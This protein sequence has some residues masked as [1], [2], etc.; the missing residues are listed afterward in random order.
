MST[1]RAFVPSESVRP[2][3]LPVAAEGVPEAMGVLTSHLKPF[4]NVEDRDWP[5]VAGWMVNHLIAGNNSPI[6]MLL[7]TNGSGKST[8]CN[9]I[10]YAVE[11][12]RSV[13]DSLEFSGKKDDVMVTL[14][15]HKVAVFDNISKISEDLSDNL[16]QVVYGKTYQKRKLRTDDDL[17]DLYIKSSVIMN[18]I[19][20][21]QLREDLKDRMVVLNLAGTVSQQTNIFDLKASQVEHHPQVYG[22][23][24]TLVSAVMRVLRDENIPAPKSRARMDDYARVLGALDHLLGTE[25]VARYLETLDESAEDAQDDPLLLHS[26]ALIRRQAN[27]DEE[28]Q[29]WSGWLGTKE[30]MDAYNTDNDTWNARLSG[31]HMEALTARTVPERLTRVQAEWARLGVE[32]RMGEKKRTTV[33]KRQQTAYPVYIHPKAAELVRE[34]RSLDFEKNGFQADSTNEAL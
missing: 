4:V 13:P 2:I 15:K 17:V 23:L 19:S 7:G 22:A 1:S 33:N 20:T 29:V 18:G 12:G 34:A 10:N 11:G 26:V 32:I 3:S 28:T 30:L 8:A 25:S 27:Y 16:A 31:V 5:L 9:A 21:G 14:S 6:L 24:L